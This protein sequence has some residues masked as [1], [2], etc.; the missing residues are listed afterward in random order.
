MRTAT[1][2]LDLFRV[3]LDQG[4]RHPLLTRQEEVELNQAYRLGLDAQGKLADCADDD[5]AR[6][7]LL[8]TAERG[9]WARRTMVE[10]NLRLVGG[11]PPRLR[12]ALEDLTAR[13]RQVLV[14]RF[15]M[16]GGEPRTLEEVGIDPRRLAR[17]GPPAGAGRPG[18]PSG[19]PPAGRRAEDAPPTPSLG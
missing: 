7:D 5:P 13:Q 16:D 18:T 1:Q 19:G 17:T 3:Y 12:Q 6:P 11:R 9:E 15:G 8:A 10:S 14:P 4:G 2:D